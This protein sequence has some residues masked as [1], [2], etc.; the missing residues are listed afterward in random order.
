MLPTPSPERRA[1]FNIPIPPNVDAESLARRR[2]ER[3]DRAKSAEAN[4]GED[5]EGPRTQGTGNILLHHRSSVLNHRPTARRRSRTPFRVSTPPDEDAEPDQY[6]NGEERKDSDSEEDRPLNRNYYG[7]T[8]DA[9]GQ[10]IDDHDNPEDVH[11]NIEHIDEDADVDGEYAVD[12]DDERYEHE[13]DNNEPQDD[14][15]EDELQDDEPQDD[16]PQDDEP[17]DDEEQDELQDDNALQDDED[18]EQGEYGLQD[19]DEQAQDEDSE[20]MG[21]LQTKACTRPSF[22]R[23]IFTILT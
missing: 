12:E 14:E 11:E 3:R 18:E 8:V 2:R 6:V 4:S 15:E 13:W 22:I 9:Y 5:S 1:H 19:E 7:E 17:Y 21:A 20:P 10:V 23:M 16:E